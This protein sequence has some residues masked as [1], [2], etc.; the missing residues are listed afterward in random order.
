MAEIDNKEVETSKGADAQVFS[1]DYVKE[2][3]NDGKEARIALSEAKKA[4]EQMQTKEQEAQTKA[5]EEQKRFEELY[6]QTKMELDAFKQRYNEVETIANTYKE[7]QE[8]RK[9]A[10]LEK[11]PENKRETYK[12]LDVMILEDIVSSYAPQSI[13]SLGN[14]ISTTNAP[15]SLEGLNGTQIAELSAK[16]PTLYQQL[17]KQ[18]LNKGI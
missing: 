16:N 8:R 15:T 7:E 2:L 14:D 4:L 12:A 10:L 1:A 13:N 5:L 11:L 3:R 6:N 18:S 9:A 17:I